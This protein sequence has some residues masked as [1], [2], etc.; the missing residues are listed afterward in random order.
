MYVES[1]DTHQLVQAHPSEG[2][3]KALDFEES[4][5]LADLLDQEVVNVLIEL[6]CMVAAMRLPPENELQL[7]VGLTKLHR[8]YICR[9][10]EIELTQRPLE[11][12]HL[13]EDLSGYWH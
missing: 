2:Q 3:S 6:D 13:R 7:R 12:M 5:C 9:L 4:L 1:D 8:H 11:V 10:Q